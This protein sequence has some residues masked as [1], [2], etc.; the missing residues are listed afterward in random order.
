V[1]PFTGVVENYCESDLA[2]MPLSYVVSN[3]VLGLDW[4]DSAIGMDDDLKL[5]LKTQ[6]LIVAKVLSKEDIQAILDF[7]C[8][9]PTIRKD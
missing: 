2:P 6:R 8:K 7:R 1:R 9:F 4:D 5:L 3:M